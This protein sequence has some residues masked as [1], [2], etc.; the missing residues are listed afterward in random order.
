MEFPNRPGDRRKDSWME[1][2]IKPTGNEFFPTN[3]TGEPEVS[4]A[5]STRAIL[6]NMP[7]QENFKNATIDLLKQNDRDSA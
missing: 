3:L 2:A 7:E 1:I 4:S 5:G 6:T